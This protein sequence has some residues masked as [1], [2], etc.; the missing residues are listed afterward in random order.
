VLDS[1][2]LSSSQRASLDQATA[3]Y[4]SNVEA[5]GSYLEPRGISRG[6]ALSAHLGLVSDPIPGH[7]R[8]KGWMSIPYLTQAGTVAMKFRCIADH[9]CK[10]E[11]CQR[12]DAPSGQK[13]RLFN[14]GVLAKGG[15]VC[16]VLEGELK[17]LVC[18]HEVGV[19]AV[20][21]SAGIWLEHW[22]RCFADFN[23]VVVIADNDQ[24][25]D[26]SNPGLKHAK[27]KVMKTLPNAELVIPPPGVQ[28]D[29]WVLAEGVEMVRKA[30]G[31]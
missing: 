8:F 11:H 15:E 10:A 28:L 5:L 17:A 29:E 4:H 20:G 24:K 9:D 25:E 22:P 21:T 31:L 3:L 23:R 12:Y 7:E 13:A 19:P 16:A 30:M 1:L 14:A 2:L 18:T 26:G 27:D 6:A